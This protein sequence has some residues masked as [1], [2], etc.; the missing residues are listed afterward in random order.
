MNTSDLYLYSA[1]SPKL[2][3][4]LRRLCG[5]AETVFP[6]VISALASYKGREYELFAIRLDISK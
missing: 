5:T 4:A 1:E 2:I 6:F 3:T